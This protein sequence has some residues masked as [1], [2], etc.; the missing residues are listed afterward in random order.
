LATV[1]FQLLKKREG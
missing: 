1:N